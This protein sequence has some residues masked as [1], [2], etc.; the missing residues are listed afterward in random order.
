MSADVIEDP[1]FVQ[2][3]YD[4]LIETDNA[5]FKDGIEGLCVLRFHK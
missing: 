3:V 1:D 4:Y 5:W 2:Q